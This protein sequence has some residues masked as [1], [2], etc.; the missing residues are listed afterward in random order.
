METYL[1]MTRLHRI[2]TLLIM[3]FCL[4]GEAFSEEGVGPVSE[5]PIEITTES[6]PSGY[7]GDE[8]STQ[9][10]A[11]G[12]QGTYYFLSAS[13]PSGL[14][15]DGDGRVHGKLKDGPGSYVVPVTVTDPKQPDQFNEKKFNLIIHEPLRILSKKIDPA[16]V[17]VE[18]HHSVLLQGGAPDSRAVMEG[19]PTGLVMNE[20]G[21]ISGTP[22]QSSDNLKLVLTYEDTHAPG[23]TVS[24]K[25]SLT[26]YDPL[27]IASISPEPLRVGQNLN[28]D[29]RI[30]EGSGDVL[31]ESDNLPKGL[32]LSP[33]GRLSGVPDAGR[34][35]YD[36]TVR[37][38]DQTVPVTVE[39]TL[40]LTLVDF[41][42]DIFESLETRDGASMN[43]MKPGGRVQ[44]HT[45]DQPG[46]HDIVLLDLTGLNKG[47]V[48]R[49]RTEPRTKATRPRLT[50]DDSAGKQGLIVDETDGAGYGGLVYVCEE[51]GIIRVT[52]DEASGE[53][54]D[55][56]LSLT[57][58][59]PKIRL[60]TEALQ[61]QQNLG[62]V[63]LN[64]QAA[65]GSGT[66][67]FSSNNLPSH[68][69]ITPQGLIQG[70]LS[71]PAGIYPVTIQVRDSLWGNLTDEK[72]FQLTVVD[73]FPDAFEKDGDDQDV[74]T[75]NT[76]APGSLVQNHTFHTPG[77][78][79][80]VKLNL[81][82]LAKDHV[83]CIRT[84]PL[85]R[86]T[87]TVLTVLD[88]KGM[89]MYSDRNRTDGD[90]SI[91]FL[92]LNGP[93]PAF[94]KI[95]EAQGKTGDYG[96]MVEDKGPNIRMK[97][98]TVPDA[99]SKGP[100]SFQLEA[101]LGS[102][103]YRFS[104]KDFPKGLTLTD[105][106]LIEGNLDLKPGSYPL[107]VRVND[108][109]YTGMAD[110]RRFD[111]KVVEFFPD[112]YETPGDE[113]VESPTV[114][115]PGDPIQLHTLN[116]TDDCDVIRLDLTGVPKGHV[117]DIQTSLL[118]K[119]TA[120]TLWLYDEHQTLL[121]TDEDRPVSENLFS[122]LVVECPGPGSLYL[123]VRSREQV[124]GDYG[125][126]LKDGG[127][128]VRLV[129]QEVPDVLIRSVMDFQMMAAEG[130]GKYRF[131]AE[132]LCPGLT[133]SP[134]GRIS[135]NITVP[136]GAY[137]FKVTVQDT[138]YTGMATQGEYILKVVDYFPDA[139][140][141]MND[142]D[143]MTA[144][145]FSPGGADQ[146][147]CFHEPGD[148]DWL[149]LDLGTSTPGDV[150][151]IKTR[152]R[153]KKTQTGIRLFDAKGTSLATQDTDEKGRGATIVFPCAT[154]G[155][156]L[157]QIREIQNQTGD[158]SLSVNNSGQPLQFVTENLNFAESVESYVQPLKVQGGCGTYRFALSQG[159]WPK[160]LNLNAETGMITGKNSDWGSFTVTV[161][162]TDKKYP[163]N[164]CSKQFGMEAYMGKKL[165]GESLFAFPHYLSGTF[166]LDNSDT[167][168]QAFP[169]DIRG[170]TKGNLR[171]RIVDNTIP[172][173]R[174][175]M[176][177][178]TLTGVLDLKEQ[179]PVSCNQ[180]KNL[181]MDVEV[182]VRDSVY[183]NNTFVF[184]YEIAAK[185][186]SY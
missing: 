72:T 67:V 16:M 7:Q 80:M 14:T 114:M 157:L 85:T 22:E 91:V 74:D 140:E 164:R 139:F 70:E 53:T 133:M 20:Q 81:S 8:Y 47:D 173:E 15:L 129:E 5:T 108:A 57:R 50:L 116:R 181:D 162:A 125:L 78:V 51:P 31:F 175:V 143:E 45:F 165:S 82:A 153:E 168:T 55:Y 59:G 25:M 170:G 121:A 149:H 71:A 56:G 117:L 156:Y 120:T 96:L 101:G 100:F 166:S 12:G 69:E 128:K 73:F 111:L 90:M 40:T 62:P 177:F 10:H 103:S 122:R 26:V 23:H 186:L 92:D 21:V 35:H 171:Y 27:T 61:D 29:I 182:E 77:D 179:N 32:E 4:R 94:I 136:R 163:E 161:L 119:P 148:V 41:L 144:N 138:Y 180:Y 43:T 98:E 115:K 178:N 3:V 39:K 174:F 11:Q 44:E 48:I 141:A 145:T 87:R 9:I 109:L 13:L 137:P 52:I 18:Y 30:E 152:Y 107:D 19:L 104:G 93:I 172:S 37:V 176:A 38:T 126:S 142:Q 135:G 105:Q 58:L 183:T 110:S 89:S 95:E 65:Q 106:G 1:H 184:H 151:I 154:P 60:A 79:D 169:G 66:Y 88:E 36:F 113:T 160:G 130:S 42:P 132:S 24:K 75:A 83:L 102:G 134:D 34:G 167:K 64:I 159:T 17:G 158:Y 63:H 46:D 131:Q 68:L 84:V 97:T 99:L 54:G 123:F 118:T 86:K 112:A 76:L 49:L 185:C 33:S 155:Q 28:M 124:V 2:L 146:D 150:I 147:H 6:L 127:P